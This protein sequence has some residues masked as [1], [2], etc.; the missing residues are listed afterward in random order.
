MNS[1]KTFFV[2]GRPDTA[3]EASVFWRCVYVYMSACVCQDISEAISLLDVQ[4]TNWAFPLSSIRLYSLFSTRDS[5]SSFAL[6]LVSALSGF[7]V[8]RAD[9]KTDLP[10]CRH[11]SATSNVSYHL[12]LHTVVWLVCYILLPAPIS[13]VSFALCVTK[14][15]QTEQQ[16]HHCHQC[17]CHLE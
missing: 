7:Q 5:T 15:Q 16:V 12:R 6:F 8:R 1:L 11:W 10:V 3:G 4:R 14:K 13:G 9:T 2:C 17:L